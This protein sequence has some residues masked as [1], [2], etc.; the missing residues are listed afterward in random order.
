MQ[1][2]MMNEQ[3][4]LNKNEYI[5]L[6]WSYALVSAR[7]NREMRRVTTFSIK[8]IN[9]NLFFIPINA[10]IKGTVKA[11]IATPYNGILNISVVYVYEYNSSSRKKPMTLEPAVRTVGRITIN[12]TAE[13]T[14]A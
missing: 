6:L 10:A 8:R 3:I 1:S 4:S 13:I 11:E 2:V 12:Q 7:Y 9:T 14:T 5:Y